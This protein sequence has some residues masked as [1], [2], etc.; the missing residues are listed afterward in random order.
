MTSSASRRKPCAGL[1]FGVSLFSLEELQI[2]NFKLRS[3]IPQGAMVVYR[4]WMLDAVD[5]Q[6]LVDFIGSRGAAPLTS[7]DIYLRCHQL[8]NWYP[9]ISDFTP[10]TR[11]FSADCDLSAEL[12]ALGW[13]KYFLKDYVKS[14]N[15]REKQQRTKRSNI[16]GNRP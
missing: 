4:G 16:R 10:E 7:T 5:Y 2:G 14:L 1:G 6:K 3:P 9:L 11:I 15:Q 8:P 13:D 12:S